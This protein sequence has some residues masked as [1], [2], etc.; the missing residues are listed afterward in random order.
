MKMNIEIFFKHTYLY[1]KKTYICWFQMLDNSRLQILNIN[2]K[3]PNISS[4][5][6]LYFVMMKMKQIISY[7]CTTK[8]FQAWELRIQKYTE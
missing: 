7:I 5:I 1:T 2:E 8:Y 4:Q 6:I 3:F